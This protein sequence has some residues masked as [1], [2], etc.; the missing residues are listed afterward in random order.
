MPTVR[1]PVMSM[2]SPVI[3]LASEYIAD[4]RDYLRA[5]QLN[6]AHSSADRLCSCGVDQIEPANAQR[7]GGV[8]DFGA[9]R[10][11]RADVEGAV[12]DLS[13]ILLLAYRRPASQC[14][15]AITD[16]PVVRPMQLPSFLVRVG[17]EARRVHPDRMRGRAELRGGALVE[18]DIGGE[19]FGGTADDG[20]HEW[21]PIARRADDRLGC[22]ADTYP[23]GQVSRLGLG[24]DVGVLE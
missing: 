23:G 9:D 1:I 7:L 24:D 12:L 11:G 6:G 10:L 19:A 3:V 13:L 14:A 15:D 18:V 8:G 2:L 17:D 22:T 5:V 16:D 21:K 4:H 20:E